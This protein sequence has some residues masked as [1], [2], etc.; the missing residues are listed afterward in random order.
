MPV[1]AMSLSASQAWAVTDVLD[2]PA[3]KSQQ[4]H[5]YLLLDVDKAG[6]RI[7]AVGERGH[8]L[9]S[10][11]GAA[12][13]QQAE[14]PVSVL[15]TAVDFADEKNGL[16]VGHSGVILVSQDGGE[17]W[18]K[19]FDGI[20]ANKSII[21]QAEDFVAAFEARRETIAEEDLED[22]E[23]NLEEA[24]F[25]LEDAVFDAEVGAS[26]PFLDVYQA[27]A[28]EGIAVGAYGLIFKTKDGGETWE[29]YGDRIGNTDRFH[30][31]A[32]AAIPGGTVLVVGESGVM[33]RSTDEGESW[34]TLESPY[35]GSY[36]GLTATGEENVVLAYGLRGNLFRSEDAGLTWA[37]IDTGSESTLMG[38]DYTSSGSVALVG[39]AG[40]VLSSTD[41]GKTFSAAIRANR[42]GN[43]AT[44]FLD[45]QRLVVVG[46]SGADLSSTDAKDL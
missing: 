17:T 19:K 35:D 25:A 6:Q 9:L 38:G 26:K 46:E 18:S 21:K 14:V 43:A 2:T 5:D 23:Y 29:N 42:L 8:I 20:E 27:S 28:Q 44:V 36:F 41:G 13:W 24:Q 39:N 16:A 15:V 33:F 10:D 37:Q 4:G 1:L 45:E 32:I 31:N 34:E 7:V 40:S 3:A 30:L 22:Y 11:D 12:T